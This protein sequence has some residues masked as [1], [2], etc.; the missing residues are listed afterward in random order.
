MIFTATEEQATEASEFLAEQFGSER[1]RDRDIETIIEKAGPF[2]EA[3]EYH[4]DYH[5]KHGGS[6]KINFSK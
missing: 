3:E 4:Q 2:Y 6:C 1:F 5:K